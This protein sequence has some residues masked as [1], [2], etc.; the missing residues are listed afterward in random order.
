M[1]ENIERDL[2]RIRHIL[3][4]IQEITDF[5][6]NTSSFGE[7]QANKILQ[8]ACIHQLEIIGEAANHISKEITNLFPDIEWR[9]ISGL[10]NLLVHEY[11]GVDLLIVWE[12][13]QFDLPSFRDK[14][15][16]ILERLSNSG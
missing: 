16:I 3:D 13:I 9:E 6:Y 11:F 14:I 2:I 15:R 8:S 4:A 7:F 5:L 12:V 10:R 1:K